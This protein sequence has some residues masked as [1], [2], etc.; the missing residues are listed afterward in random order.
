ME[1]I[2]PA[3]GPGDRFARW[4][5]LIAGVY[6]VLIVL[7]QYSLEA[8]IARDFPPPITHPEYFY[9]FIGVALAWQVVF[10]LISRD[11]QRYRLMMLPAILEKVTFGLAAVLLY[12][13]GRVAGSLVAGGLVD[14][15]FAVLFALAFRATRGE[16]STIR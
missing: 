5:F 8:R 1:H 3:A 9:G 6:G 11:V 13:S 14:L 10:L 2:T 4:V 15:V 12:V 16:T 7:P